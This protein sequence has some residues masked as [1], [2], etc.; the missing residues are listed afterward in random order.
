MNTRHTV[1]SSLLDELTLVADGDALVGVY[2][3]HHWY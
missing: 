1:L 3:R 2:F